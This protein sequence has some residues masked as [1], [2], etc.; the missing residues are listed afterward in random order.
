MM[1]K[2]KAIVP[3]DDTNYVK[4]LTSPQN[5]VKKIVDLAGKNDHFKFSWLK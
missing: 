3:H 2:P 1:A 4:N 5:D